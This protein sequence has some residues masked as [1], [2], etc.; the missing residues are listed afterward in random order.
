M[1]PEIWRKSRTKC[2]FSRIAGRSCLCLVAENGIARVGESSVVE[3][4]VAE[5]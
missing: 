4:R 2:S 3:N 5:S 1:L